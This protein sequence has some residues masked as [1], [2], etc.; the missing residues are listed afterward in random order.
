[1]ID[2]TSRLRC[3]PRNE[4]MAQNPQV[5]SQP[6]AIFTYAHGDELLGRGKFNKSSD[7]TGA[8]PTGISFFGAGVCTGTPKPAT[9]STSG[10][11]SASSC[12]YRSAMQPVT[13]R[14]DDFLRCSSRLR[15]VS[16][17]SRRAS[18][19]NAHV[20]TTTK[21]ASSAESVANMPSANKVPIN[22]SE[23]T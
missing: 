10:N 2:C 21:S 16:I 18:S 15:I 22:L 4:G 12:P 5:R 6:S 7:G 3:G 17:D 19:M 8:D 1:M 9:K 20:F 14:R 13:T 23:S 11:S